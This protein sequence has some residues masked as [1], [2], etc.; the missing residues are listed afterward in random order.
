[1]RKSYLQIMKEAL[2]STIVDKEKKPDLSMKDW[3][4]I[5]ECLVALENI[6][7]DLNNVNAERVKDKIVMEFEVLQDMT[8][9]NFI[10]EDEEIERKDNQEILLDYILPS[11]Q[12]EESATL[13]NKISRILYKTY[14]KPMGAPL[15]AVITYVVKK[16]KEEESDVLPNS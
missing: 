4:F 1:M 13:F 6:S 11:L 10:E 14:G 16:L 8:G 5:L 15:C 2:K 3:K 7:K 12:D 9:Y